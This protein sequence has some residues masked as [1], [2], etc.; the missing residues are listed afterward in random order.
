MKY[1]LAAAA[2]MAA[3]VGGSTFAE[4]GRV[5]KDQLASL[6]LG[7]LQVISDA[8][9]REIRGQGFAFASSIASSALPGTSALNSAIAL[10]F[11]HADAET[12]SASE[13][14]L[15]VLVGTPTPILSLQIRAAVGSAGYAISNSN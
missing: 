7:G 15:D 2:M 6:G 11:S 4:E 1:A 14:E 12:A 13:F 9:G 8:E 10:G 3:M 5:A